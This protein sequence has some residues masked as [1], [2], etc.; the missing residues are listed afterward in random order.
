MEGN[1]Q[2]GT[3]SLVGG[4]GSIATA[5]F[6]T[7][8][9]DAG[10][11][12]ISA[13][14]CGATN[15]FCSPD[16]NFYGSSSTDNDHPPLSQLIQKKH[17]T[18]TAD[19]HS[20]T[21]DGN[22]FSPFTATLTGFVLQQ[23]DTGL[24]SAGK[25]SGNAGFTG[26][27]VDQIHAGSWVITPTAGTLTATNYDFTPL[28]NGTLTINKATAIISVTG[29]TFTYDRLPHVATGTA[30]GVETPPATVRNLF[31]LLDLSNTI[32]T[33]AGTYNADPW[34]FAGDIDYNSASGAV[35]DFIA[36]A[37]ATINV[38][39]Y[40]VVY[41]G[42]QHVATGTATGVGN[43]PEQLFAFLNLTQTQHTDVG[44]YTSDQWSF[45][46]GNPVNTNYNTAGPTTILDRIRSDTFKAVGQHYL[47]VNGQAGETSVEVYSQT[48]VASTGSNT[49]GLQD[50][51]GQN[52]GP[53]AARKDFY[54]IITNTSSVPV[55]ITSVK[56]N[57]TVN[58][59]STAVFV[60]VKVASMIGFENILVPDKLAPP[61][62]TATVSPNSSA[63]GEFEIVFAEPFEIPAGGRVAF[64]FIVPLTLSTDALLVGT[65][66]TGN[67]NSETTPTYWQGFYATKPQ[68]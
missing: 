50:S 53:N 45:N 20:K 51:L 10:T 57:G 52:A 54:E 46:T 68:S 49:P 16:P 24:R 39:P 29:Y 55:T 1:T 42:S 34:A 3:G 66:V 27:A 38:T 48:S 18:V 26:S 47:V 33:N 62:A 17:L 61:L 67:T 65:D 32:H 28:V 58:T 43:P 2:L 37:T 5:T 7:A 64:G 35:N 56:L 21:Y 31:A 11:H 12:L 41:D 9:L 23:T 36:K 19:N 13:V 30:T 6:S 59:Q 25:L 14:Y 60:P 63:P 15:T 4:A 40:D 22:P 44:D 8:T